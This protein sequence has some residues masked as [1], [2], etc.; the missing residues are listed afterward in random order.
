MAKGDPPGA[1]LYK[2]SFGD[3]IRKLREA[4]DLEIKEMAAALGIKYHRYQKYEIGEREAP[5]WLL[6]RIADYHRV[7]IDFLIRGKDGG[8][9]MPQMQRL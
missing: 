2:R 9:R 6:V 4:R 8:S 5:Y 3:R 1:D 7:S